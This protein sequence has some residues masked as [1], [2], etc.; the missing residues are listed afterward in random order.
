MSLSEYLYWLKTDD[1]DNYSFLVNGLLQLIPNITE[2]SP[3]MVTLPDGQQ[4]IYDIR[5]KET[6]VV[7]QSVVME[8]CIMDIICRKGRHGK[9]L[10]FAKL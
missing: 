7:L 8:R 1:N 5:I 9:T 2:F 3:E 10:E 6:P 4:K